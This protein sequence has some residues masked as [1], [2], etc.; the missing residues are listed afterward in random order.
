[1]HA[2]RVENSDRLRRVLEA[3]RANP[4]GLTTR[5]VTDVAGVLAVSATMAELRQGLLPGGTTVRCDYVART[6]H[7]ARIYR[8]RLEE[9]P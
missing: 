5:E 2:A 9:A 8:Y 3:L 6:R 1:M 4:D 7:G